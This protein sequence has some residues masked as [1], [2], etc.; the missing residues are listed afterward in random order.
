MKIMFNDGRQEGSESACSHF[1]MFD[2]DNGTFDFPPSL[3]FCWE[4]SLKSERC[5]YSV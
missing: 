5:K 3:T 4:I 2:P 1:F